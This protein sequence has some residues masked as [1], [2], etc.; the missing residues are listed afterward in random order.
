MMLQSAVY[1]V[2][3]ESSS[4]FCLDHESI[5]PYPF[6]C[7]AGEA[8]RILTMTWGNWVGHAYICYT[9]LRQATFCLGQLLQVQCIYIN[10]CNASR[11][12][13]EQIRGSALAVWVRRFLLWRCEYYENLDIITFF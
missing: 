1:V 12:E 7:L 9:L 8:F 13:L 2:K 5:C 6:L 3:L 11:A 10:T 4:M